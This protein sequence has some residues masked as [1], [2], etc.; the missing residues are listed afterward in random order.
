MRHHEGRRGG[1]PR[2]RV[3]GRRGTLVAAAAALLA[4][5]CAGRPAPRPP[6]GGGHEAPGTVAPARS[7]LASRP[8]APRWARMDHSWRK[9]DEIERWQ[10]S[11]KARISPEEWQL[12]ASLQLAEG[13]LEFATAQGGADV[14]E[15]ILEFRRASALEGFQ[16]VAGATGA[17]D[18]QRRRA[19]DG[20]RGVQRASAERPA[21]APLPASATV[22]PAGGLIPRASWGAAPPVLRE[23]RASRAPWRWITVH[24]S[25]FRSG[26]PLETVK[27]VQRDHMSNRGY[28]DVGYHYFIDREGRIIEGRSLRWQGA[29][30][31]GSNNVGNVGICLIGDFDKEKPTGAALRSLERLIVELQSKLGIPRPNVR[32][33]RAWKETQCPGEHL[34]PWFARRRGRRG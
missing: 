11:P 3:W 21:A 4:A 6:L 12:E 17:S 28:G 16:R 9:L 27:R 32:P 34:M 24:H 20:I 18:D 13:Q 15:D 10:R 1:T 29:H 19:R 5:G 30:A 7:A 14:G 33:H 26:G 8:D 2:G 23:L 25:A 22:T 31:G